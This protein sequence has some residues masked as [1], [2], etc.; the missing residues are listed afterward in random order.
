MVKD[1]SFL[2]PFSV[3]TERQGKLPSPSPVHVLT[4]TPH[5]YFFSGTLVLLQISTQ[6][7]GPGPL[8]LGSPTCLGFL[9]IPLS[10]GHTVSKLH[11]SSHFSLPLT[12]WFWS[13][14]G[15]IMGQPFGV[16]N[17]SL[18]ILSMVEIRVLTF[19]LYN[20]QILTLYCIVLYCIIL[21]SI[22]FYSILFFP[23][24]FHSISFYS[25]PLQLE[26]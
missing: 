6:E 20:K 25:I 2:A 9:L 1:L 8:D 10:Q 11:S 13:G 17:M 21:Y 4:S 12:S 26:R 22:L 15:V 24:L 7:W 23:I 19:L 14:L 18:K 5:R 16:Y 3:P